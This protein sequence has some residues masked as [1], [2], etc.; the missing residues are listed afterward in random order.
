LHWSFR[1][2]TCA[3]QK[4]PVLAHQL[5]LD[6]FYHLSLTIRDCTIFFPCFLVNIDQMN[7]IYQPA[8]TTMYEEKGSK[9]VAVVGQEEKQAFTVVVGVS[10]SGDVLPFQVIY[11]GKTDCALPSKTTTTYQESKKLGFKLCFSNITTYWST[12][13]LMCDYVHD[14][15][16]P[17]WTKQFE[18]VAGTPDGQECVLQL[19]VWSV[20]RSVQFRT[21][22]DKH[23][24]WIKY[25][26]VPGGCTGI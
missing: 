21:W 23:Y 7:I 19:D 22:L 4:T 20:H 9:Q 3:A 8:N 13:E 14:I 10:A 1:R 12:F 26:F 17:Y 18:L 2:A 25:R 15:L 6:Q 11:C 24:P 16:A 5:C